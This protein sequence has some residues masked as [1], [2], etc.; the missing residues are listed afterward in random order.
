MHALSGGCHCGN[1]S[2]DLE[3]SREPG[4]YRPRVCDCDFCR[5]HGAA[6]VSD[7]EGSLHIR[8]KDEQVL[9]IYRQGSGQAEFLLCKRCGVMIGVLYRNAEHLYATANTK[10]IDASVAF[11]PDQGVSP[12]TLLAEEKTSRWCELW[13]PRVKL[14]CRQ[15]EDVIGQ[16]MMHE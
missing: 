15:A 14:S 10:A 11:G 16:R 2:I 3:L 12:K 1:L 7:A 4:T 6:Y 8:V 13:F 9:S 5:Q